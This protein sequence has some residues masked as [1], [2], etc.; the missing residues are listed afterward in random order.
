MK[1]KNPATSHEAAQPSKAARVTN[2]ILALFLLVTIF[3]FGYMTIKPNFDTLFESARS[4]SRLKSY[5]PA[6]NYTFLEH[7]SAR[8]RSFEARFN[9]VLWK[10]DELGYMNSSVQYALG[11]DLINTGASSMVTLETGA[12]YDLP[13]YVDTSKRTSE[14]IAFAESL[15]VPFLFVFEHPTTYGENMPAGGYA[16]LDNGTRVSDEI[17]AALREGGLNVID[18][19]DVLEGEDVSRIIW[20]TDQHWTYYAALVV[21]GDVAD[22]LGLDSDM[23][24]PARFESLT[25]EEKF[26]G[27]YGQKVGTGNI[28]PDDITVFWPDY[29]TYIE[30]Y[31]ILNGEKT[32]AEGAFRDAVIKWDYLNVEGWSIEAYKA[33]GLTEDFEHYHNENAPSDMT[34]LIYKDSFGSP[35]GAF[36]SLVA[37]DVYLVD[38]RKQEQYAP[39]FVEKYQPDVVVIAY[40]QQMVCSNEYDLLEGY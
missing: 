4:Y 5:M 14:I 23:L 12:L 1:D 38:M 11:K 30:R 16:M 25:L 37:K 3:T 20:N 26:L 34:I 15:D 19:R 29:D 39:Y 28:A 21:A 36:M 40:S 7:T 24:D 17:V 9:E 8:I 13:A 22:E 18:S 27:K 10:K 33:Y 2:A 35:V 6:E 32:A 31:T